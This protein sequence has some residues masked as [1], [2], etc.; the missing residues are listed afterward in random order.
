MSI[1]NWGA[2]FGHSVPDVVP[3]GGVEEQVHLSQ[4]AGSITEPWEFSHHLDV[5]PF[6]STFWAS[7]FGQL[8]T[9]QGFTCPNHG[10][11]AFLGE[12]VED[13]VKGFTKF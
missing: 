7:P 6:V 4:P 9:Q 3:L 11:P 5:T 2:N 8:L 1:L 10:L 13:G 12:S